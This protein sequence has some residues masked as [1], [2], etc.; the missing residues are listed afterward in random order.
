VDITKASGEAEAFS[1]AKLLRSLHQAGASEALALDVWARLEPQLRRG[2]SSRR[3]HQEAFA[4]LKQLRRPVA[5]RYHLKSAIMELG[6]SGYPFERLV[7]ELFREAGYGVKVGQTLPGQCVTHEVDVVARA[8]DELVLVECKYRNMAG[9]KCDVKVPLY[10]HSRFEDIRGQQPQELRI[11]GWIATNARFTGD[12]IKYADCI[13]LKLLGWD[14]PVQDSLRHWLDRTRLYPLTVLTSLSRIQKQ[15]LLAQN[16]IL[17]RD[18]L[19][20]PEVLRLLPGG[21]S[22]TDEQQILEEC[23]QLGT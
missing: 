2:M 17:T 9:F 5:S 1:E 16:L 8:G 3:I 21:L 22:R 11:Q 4:L 13:G 7:G 15:A 23:R 18:L 10:I 20:R 14:H 19:A 6:P 12:A